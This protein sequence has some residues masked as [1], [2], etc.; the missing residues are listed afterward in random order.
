ML[1]QRE[2]R[3]SEH[4]AGGN[5]FRASVLEGLSRPHK[6]LSS[7]F[8]YDAKGSELFEEITRLPEYYPTR[9]ETAIL[10]AHAAEI[11]DGVLDGSVLVE[12]GSGS[13][14][15]TEILLGRLPRLSAYVA[16]DV[17]QSALRAAKQRLAWHFPHL[18]IHPILGDFSDRLTLPASI[19]N[20]KKIGFFPGSTIGNFEPADA[21]RLLNHFR[22]IL[23]PGGRLVVGVDLK[24]DP[25][26]LVRAYD[27]ACGVTAAFDL[28]LLARI[29]REAGGTFDLASFRHKAIYNA[30]EGRIEMHLESKRDQ[31]VRVS[32]RVFHF[33]AGETI[34]TENAYKYAI[35]E[36]RDLARA[37]QWQPRRVWTDKNNLFSVHELIAA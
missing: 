27:D 28:N 26:M 23:S 37:A 16:I 33:Q 22:T 35:A 5:D 3:S 12:F 13:S 17:S 11:V 31:D 29:N 18:E 9:T 7:R 14:C 34:H 1:G 10:E 2:D 25:A 30:D 4:L 24:K 8:L 21:V 6:S 19:A 20:R 36:F 15:K 32:D